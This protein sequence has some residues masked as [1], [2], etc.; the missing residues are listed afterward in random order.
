MLMQDRF[1]YL[2]D[3]F[4]NK[5]ATDEELAE[6]YQL[7]D[8]GK[9]DDL[10][11]ELMQDFYHQHPNNEST[12]DFYLPGADKRMLE[13][14]FQAAA[15]PAP[16]KL[17]VK[18]IR[19]AAAVAAIAL[20]LIVCRIYLIHPTPPQ[21]K[22]EQPAKQDIAPGNMGATLTLANG[23]TIRL[24]DTQN[25]EIAKEAGIVVRKTADGQLEYD[26]QNSNTNEHT[27]NTL[28]TSRGETYAVI[29]PDH[30]KVWLNAASKLTYS[31]QLLENGLRKVKLD[32]EAYFE[33]TKDAAHPFIVETR[34]QTLK[35]LGTNFNIN[36]YA[37]EA[38]TSTTLLEGSVAIQ[39]GTENNV[40]LKPNEQ[41]ILIN[42]KITVKNVDVTDVTAWK[43]GLFVFNN[44][45]LESIMRK[46]SRWYNVE[47]VYQG[48]LPA[49][50]FTGALSRSKNLSTLVGILEAPGD[51][52][53]KIDGRK[54]IIS[55]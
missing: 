4:T 40:I 26:L 51:I 23:K 22:S 20:I 38:K 39:Y 33:I 14:I 2:F 3:Q 35:V 55:K 16:K 34:E 30:S 54:I 8:Q 31:S 52:H 48:N 32:G 6:F 5:Q 47:I 29:L 46:V 36:S 12:G 53:C 1:K 18:Y 10:L 50:Q 45:S 17:S 9:H 42:Q 21:A 28:S 43:N 7:V 13:N 37:D 25:G 41:A 19:I 49:L 27:L 44:E 24:G 11:Q 15:N